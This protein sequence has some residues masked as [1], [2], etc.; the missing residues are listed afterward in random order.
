[1]RN[2]NELARSDWYRKSFNTDYIRIYEYKDDTA[3]Q[4]T[5]AI[6]TY[7][8]S[9]QTTASLPNLRILD[10]ACGWGRHAIELA[11]R[12]HTVTGID[13]SR[14][15]LDEA[16]R[17]ADKANVT[18]K[19]L[20]MDMREIDFRDEFD[21]AINMFTSFGYFVDETENAKV[22]EKVFHS[23]V[24]GG[25]FLLDLD[26]PSYFIRKRQ[27]LEQ[28]RLRRSSGASVESV[29]KEELLHWKRERRVTYSFLDRRSKKND[30]FLRCN[31]YDYEDIKTLL[32]QARFKVYPIA[33][34][35]FN[36][37]KH[38]LPRLSEELARL[39][40]AAYRP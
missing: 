7:L 13:L 34:G 5:D 37:S 38:P 24:S 12:G 10:L 22:L 3:I 18:V 36:D 2:S 25:R 39:I 35:D 31:L 8:R 28:F 11:R 4:E 32:E 29:L 9:L 17:R 23:L 30:I 6:L 26:N 19:W 27:R 33:W 15:M 16:K 20:C 40:V 14:V 21:V 1:M